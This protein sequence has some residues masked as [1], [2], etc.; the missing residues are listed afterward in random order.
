MPEL[1]GFQTTRE[2]RSWGGTF[3]S[4]PI[5]ALTASAMAEDR[6]KCFDAGMNDFLSKPLMLPTLLDALSRWNPQPRHR[7]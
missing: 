1:D 4:L 6:Q 3:T 5:I 7:V 2:I